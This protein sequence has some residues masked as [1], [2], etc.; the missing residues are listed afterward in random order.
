MA[1][2]LTARPEPPH[3]AVRVIMDAVPY[4]DDESFESFRELV[5]LSQV[6]EARIGSHRKTRDHN[7]L[8][9]MLADVATMTYLTERLFEFSRMDAKSIPY[10]EPTRNDLEEALYRLGGPERT[11]APKIRFRIEEALD[12]EVSQLSTDDQSSNVQGDED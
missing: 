9:R 6:I 12:R 5:V 10:L 7:R 1:E 8:S 2:E 11:C 4:V 3:S